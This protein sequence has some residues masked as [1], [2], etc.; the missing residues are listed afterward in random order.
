MSIGTINILSAI[1]LSFVVA[2]V[3]SINDSDSAA[4]AVRRALLRA[5]KL[6]G[7]MALIGL[8]VLVL[9]LFS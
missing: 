8:I 1:F 2:G 4:S 7:G 5:A 9:T 3:I 6:I